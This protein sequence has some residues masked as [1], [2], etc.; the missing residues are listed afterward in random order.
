MKEFQLSLDGVMINAISKGQNFEIRISKLEAER[1]LDE[2]L[3]LPFTIMCKEYGEDDDW[4]EVTDEDLNENCVFDD[5]YQ[6]FELWLSNEYSTLPTY[7]QAFGLSPVV[8]MPCDTIKVRND[9]QSQYIETKDGLEVDNEFNYPSITVNNLCSDEDITVIFIRDEWH[10]VNN[11][12][13]E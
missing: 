8:T 11:I 7:E 12:D 5:E 3:L 10:K 4:I 6:T 2:G 1:L 9:L 13:F